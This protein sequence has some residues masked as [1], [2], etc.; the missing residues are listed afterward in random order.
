HHA[1]TPVDLN[2][3]DEFSTQLVMTEKDWVKCAAFAD[4]NMWYLEVNARLNTYIETT[5]INDLATLVQSNK[6]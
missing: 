2:W 1:F 6:C 3:A 5:L 4:V